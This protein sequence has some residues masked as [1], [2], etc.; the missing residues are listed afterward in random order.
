M[1][2]VSIFELLLKVNVVPDHEADKP[3]NRAAATGEDD[4]CCTTGNAH[5]KEILDEVAGVMESGAISG[6]KTTKR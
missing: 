2:Q 1:P 6:L 5:A 4:D 3:K